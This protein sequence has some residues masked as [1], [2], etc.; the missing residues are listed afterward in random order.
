MENRDTIIDVP[1]IEVGNAQDEPGGT[2][3]TVVL[4]RG[5]AVGGVDVR[6]GA[7]STR[8][9]D[10][11]APENIIRQIHAV[12][13]GGGS[14]F[15]LAGAVG[16][17]AYLEEHGVGFDVGVTH[18][19]VVPGAT[20]FDLVVGDHLAR[21]DE[22][23]GRRA[24]QD[25]ASHVFAQG[26]V[27]AGMGASVGK[28]AGRTRTMKG[29]LGTASHVEGNLVVG[30]IV[31]VNCFGNVRDPQTGV[32]LAGTLDERRDRIVS[33]TALLRVAG[34]EANVF[35]E[36]TTIGVIATNA[37]LDKAQ[38][39][40]VAIMAHDG[41]ARAIDPVHTAWDGDTV[42]TMATGEADGN[43]S[44]VGSMA[45]E[46]MARAVA[47]AVRHAVSRYGIPAHREIAGA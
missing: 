43:V 1:G 31:V 33:S 28:A 7:P 47:S 36:N 3:C 44:T 46:V 8:E 21:P 4:A 27:G 30:A 25:A 9:T 35:L 26:N 45:A 10:A 32:V 29:G 40:R 39:R 41:Y 11:L 12:Y 38:A 42:F 23:M 19:P 18:V 16:V 13:L 37:R 15:G 14:T 2:G 6:G 5:G 20:I 34:A 22:A 17:A 24:C